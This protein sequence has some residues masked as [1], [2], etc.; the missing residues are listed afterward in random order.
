MDMLIA[1]RKLINLASGENGNDFTKLG[2]KPV[3]ATVLT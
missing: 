2:D 1:I 3:I